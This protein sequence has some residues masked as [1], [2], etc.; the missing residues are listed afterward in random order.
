MVGVG[1]SAVFSL[2]RSGRI[3][4]SDRGTGGGGPDHRTTCCAR[5]TT[6]STLDLASASAGLRF[7]P[8]MRPSSALEQSHLEMPTPSPDSSPAPGARSYRPCLA[9]GG[10]EAA[11]VVGRRVL[12]MSPRETACGEGEEI[13]RG[14]SV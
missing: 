11:R 9:S 7:R 14:R 2:G 13:E 3:I 5:S 10:M 1:V 4:S 12:R 6:S 8:Q